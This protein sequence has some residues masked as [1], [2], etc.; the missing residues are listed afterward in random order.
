MGTM[1]VQTAKALTTLP[2]KVWDVG[3][4]IVGLEKRDPEGPMSLVGGGRIAGETAAHE[5][6]PV[7]EKAVMLLMLIAGF[8]FFIGMF[9]FEIGRAHVCTPVTNA[10]L[11]C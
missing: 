6:F 10:H 2:A 1:T 3:Q 8:N 7:K 5:E 4:A 11:V 9:N